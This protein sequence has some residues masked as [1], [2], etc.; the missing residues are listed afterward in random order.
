MDD[1]KVWVP[2]GDAKRSIV[3][4]KMP[5]VVKAQ[6]ETLKQQ[7]IEPKDVPFST[8]AGERRPLFR[9]S[10]VRKVP[11]RSSTPARNEPSSWTAIAAI[12]STS[13]AEKRPA[14]EEG[15][16]NVFA[17]RQK[18]T[19]QRPER[20]EHVTIFEDPPTTSPPPPPAPTDSVNPPSPISVQEMPHLPSGSL[21]EDGVDSR[22]RVSLGY[23]ANFLILPYTFPGGLKITADTTVWKKQDAFQ[24]LRPLILE[25]MATDFDEAHDPM[26]V[27]ASVARYLIKGT[28]FSFFSF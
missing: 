10:K 9:K 23:L 8:M 27:Q 18:R 1:P 2:L 28:L 5:A 26:E 17:P 13:T 24:A 15:R 12:T 4:K 11:T 20:I 6:L 7:C 19:A 16:P 22:P 21:N 3:P 14:L 25:H